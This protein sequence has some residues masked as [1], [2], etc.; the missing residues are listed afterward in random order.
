[1]CVVWKIKPDKVKV[2]VEGGRGGRGWVES[3]QQLYLDL[4]LTLP[5]KRMWRNRIKYFSQAE[6]IILPSNTNQVDMVSKMTRNAA[7][8]HCGCSFYHIPNSKYFL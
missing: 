1:M 2:L 6:R 8:F 7:V 5:N 3:K 4:F